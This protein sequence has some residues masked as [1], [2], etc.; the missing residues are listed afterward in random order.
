MIEKKINFVWNLG[1]DTGRIIHPMEIEIRDPKYDDAWYRIEATRTMNIGE[2]KVS[3]M[4]NEGRFE[5]S[6]LINGATSHN[7]TILTIEQSSRIYLGGPPE[8]IKPKDLSTQHGLSVNVH[9]LFVDYSQVG[10]WHFTSS[11]GQCDGAM[12]GASETSDSSRHFNGQGYS[13]V[14]SSSSRAIPK[15]IFSLQIT[16]KTLDENALLFL[17]VDEKN[18]SQIFIKISKTFLI[19][20]SSTE[21]FN[22]INSLSW[23]TCI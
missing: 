22:I 1:A 20:Y 15:K 21:S 13:V 17:A 2:L 12:L 10:L 3:R 9:Q 19:Y 6:N 5:H 8:N 14:K 23:K 4:N 7:F 11:Q 16:F 18:V